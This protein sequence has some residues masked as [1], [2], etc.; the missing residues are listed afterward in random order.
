MRRVLRASPLWVRVSG[1]GVAGLWPLPRSG[2][3]RAAI[4]RVLSR[5][6]LR[7]EELC[8]LRTDDLDPAHRT[9]RTRMTR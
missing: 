3:G 6:G 2:A 1:A 7:R 8:S 9:L 4:P 5:P